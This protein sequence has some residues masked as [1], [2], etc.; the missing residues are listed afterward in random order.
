MIGNKVYSLGYVDSSYCGNEG[1][2]NNWQLADA[3]ATVVVVVGDN[4]AAGCR[5]WADRRVMSFI[6]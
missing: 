4:V 1:N 2:E 6:L 3:A 5:S